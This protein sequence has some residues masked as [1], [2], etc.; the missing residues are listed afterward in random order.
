MRLALRL[1]GIGMLFCATGCAVVP[2]RYQLAAEP[3]MDV[4]GL[5]LGPSSLQYTQASLTRKQQVNLLVQ[6]SQTKCA[7]FVDSMFAETAGSGLVLDA[8]STATSA[9]SSIITPLSVAHALGATSTILGATKTGISA[10]YLNTLSISHIAQAI[11]ATYDINIKSYI[12]S[13]STADESQIDVFQ[14]R[15]KILSYHKMC[16]LASA[17]GSISSTLQ[18]S[19][20]AGQSINIPPYTV[21]GVGDITPAGLATALAVF[22]NQNAAFQ[23]AGVTAIPSGS[24]VISFTMKTSLTFSVTS[25]NA[26]FKPTIVQGTPTTPAQLTI[27]I[28][29]SP[30]TMSKKDTVTVA[31]TAASSQPTGGAPTAPAG[32]SGQNVTTPH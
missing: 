3:L 30:G 7:H 21:T 11:Q 5:Q 32:A 26:N 13:L 6:D 16:S 4:P 14:E 9:V 29:G 2:Q 1:V 17:E 25:S 22:L 18:S 20:Q 27:A 8:L 28:T 12:D 10:N 31:L 19:P 23:Q 24:A 15:S